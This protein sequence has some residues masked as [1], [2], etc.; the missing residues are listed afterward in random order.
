M[1]SRMR[2][3]TRLHIGF[4]SLL[5]LLIAVGGFS[6]Y[7]MHTL[8]DLTHRMYR[9]PFTVSNTVMRIDGNIVRIH[10]AMK[11]IALA[12]SLQEI[13]AFA[14]KAQALESLV[15]DDFRIIKERFLG[16]PESYIK[17]EKLFRQWSPIR[18]DVINLM[19]EGRVREAS[20]ITKGRGAIH[21]N[22]IINA[23]RALS[24]YASN[25]AKDFY[26]HSGKL[27]NQNV[28]LM[29]W[30]LGISVIL[31]LAFMG[32]FIRSIVKPVAEIAEVASSI[33]HGDLSRRITYDSD[34]EIG[35]MAQS[36]TRMMSGVIGEGVSIKNSIPIHFWTTDTD[37]KITFANAK[38]DELLSG[39]ALLM[40]V[41]LRDVFG[42]R[43][44]ELAE[45]ARECLDTNSQ[46]AR[47][48]EF[49]APYGH[50]CM[51]MVI[52]PMYNLENVAVGIIGVGLDTTERKL[53]EKEIRKAMEIAERSNRVKGEFLAM[54]SHELRT[55]L[56]GVLGML[57]L[58]E[59]TQVDD[60]QQ[61]YLEVAK[62]SGTGLLGI[63]SDILDIS[64]IESDSITLSQ[65][66]FAASDLFEQV[67]AATRKNAEHKGLNF[68][69]DLSETQGVQLYADRGRIAQILLNL[70]SN[71]I[72]FTHAGHV[73]LAA[74]ISYPPDRCPLLVVSVSDTGIGI[75]PVDMERLFNPFQQVN[76]AIT[77]RNDGVGLGL[78][79]VRRLVHLMGGALHLDSGSGNGAT[80]ILSLPVR[81]AE[82]PA[83]ESD[84]FEGT[85]SS[86]EDFHILI[87]EDNE[88][89]RKVARGL[90]ARRGFKV[91]VAEDGQD[92][93]ITMRQHSFD[94]VLMDI[95]MPVMDGLEAT[96]RIRKGE[97]GLTGSGVPIVAMT[98]YAMQGDKENFLKEGMTD[99]LTKP[100]QA[101]ALYETVERVLR[102]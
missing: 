27:L 92:A 31:G 40:G 73:E 48:M 96:R 69:M 3:K 38:A 30:L 83:T 47:D 57:Q 53:A 7:E 70:V 43:G 85:R 98:A 12:D 35:A 56:N 21:V 101:E 65:E 13:E 81:V 25:K 78:Y 42:A 86:A 45:M 34:D 4:G 23:M 63:L 24:D 97:G 74:T 91:M 93:L 61:N 87:V 95:K 84:A 1:F 15:L 44:P 36:L 50:R 100:V 88:V 22:K 80:F 20:N 52:S 82:K 58:L 39:G 67:S 94:L 6:L 76:M 2:L 51:T 8:A 18:E 49:P 77:S 89:S 102:G 10:R 41:N 68:V 19:L 33:S 79:I 90:L 46:I 29:T 28:Q 32:Y 55:P 60:E 11:D 9:H 17:A 54:M 14:A 16:D 71:A 66:E 64:K 72:K 99:Y 75:A 37:M 5:V 26:S 62:A 59:T